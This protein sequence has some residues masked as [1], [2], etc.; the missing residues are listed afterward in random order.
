MF[1][2]VARMEAIKIV[3]ASA[4]QLQLQGF[5]LDVKLVFLNEELEEEVSVE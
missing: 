4:A 3:S 5:E 1:A 2:H